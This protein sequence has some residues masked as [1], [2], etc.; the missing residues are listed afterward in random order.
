[1]IVQLSRKQKVLLTALLVLLAFLFTISYFLFIRPIQN[2]ITKV[3]NDLVTE[4][5]ILEALEVQAEE[6]KNNTYMNTTEL[7]K[8][9]PVKPIVEQFILDLEKAEVVSNSTITRMEFTEENAEGQV[10]AE[11]EVENDSET[12]TTQNQQITVVGNGLKKITVT[13]SVES[14]NYF[15]LEE[16]LSTIENQTRIAQIESLTFTGLPEF[17]SIDQSFD[18]LLYNVTISTFYYPELQDLIDQLP[19]LEVPEPSK[20]RNPLT[21][22]GSTEENKE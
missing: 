7:Q 14:T 3:E 11:M 1:M 4:Q 5:S 12:E 9:I 8:R 6:T 18:K 22:I 20:K 2:D 10:E 21:T 16:F 17:I 19:S 13:L 15:D